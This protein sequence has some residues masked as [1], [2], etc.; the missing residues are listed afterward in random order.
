M[1]PTGIKTGPNLAQT[2]EVVIEPSTIKQQAPVTELKG[3]ASGGPQAGLVKTAKSVESA[4]E[5]LAARA[6][7][8]A[9]IA[10]LDRRFAPIDGPLG[11]LAVTAVDQQLE[12]I[13]KMAGA[14]SMSV[15][16]AEDKRAVMAELARQ[17]VSPLLKTLLPDNKMLEGLAESEVAERQAHAEALLGEISVRLLDN[18][19]HQ[20]LVELM[21][22]T[23]GVVLGPKNEAEMG[24]LSAEIDRVMAQQEAGG[25]LG[26]IEEAVQKGLKLEMAESK[27]IAQAQKQLE[28]EPGAAVKALSAVAER[29]DKH[30]RAVQDE[31]WLEKMGPGFKLNLSTAGEAK[32]GEPEKPDPAAIQAIID[33]NLKKVEPKIAALH[34]EIAGASTSPS[35][36]SRFRGA[37]IGAAI[38]DCLGATYEFQSR[39]KIRLTCGVNTEFLGGGPFNWKAGEPTDDTQMSLAIARS[40]VKSGGFDQADVGKNF[41][42]WLNTKPKDIGGLT[43]RTLGAMRAGMEPQMAGYTAWAFDGFFNAGNGSVMRSGP[44]SLLTA[45]KSDQELTRV[46]V[47]SSELTH[48]D[49]RCT[50][51]TAAIAKGVSLVMKGETDVAKKVAAWLEDKSPTLAASLAKVPELPAEDVR[52]D[53]YVVSTV[54]AAFWALEHSKNFVDGII[55][56]ANHGEDTD[57]AAATAGILLGAKYGLDGIPESWRSQVIGKD[58]IDALA[59]EIHKLAKS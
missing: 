35:E 25:M 31:A 8:Q 34:A 3:E 55:F 53:G 21:P 2:G 52:T 32:V 19:S 50:W 10:K 56:A 33:A 7:N 44:A 5:I 1:R 39:E 15:L 43:R 47:Q 16:D 46:A 22:Q 23:A 13:V 38:G 18:F 28:L 36:Q 54:Q 41:V 58:E 27:V 17:A 37:M 20:D 24:A 12:L 59:T 26:R 11:Q 30:I 45:F 40:I 14:P 9:T 6:A 51:G 4:A 49:T 48:A 42:G 57:T 29:A